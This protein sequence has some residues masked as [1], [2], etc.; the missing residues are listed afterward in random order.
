MAKIT[1]VYMLV[2]GQQTG[3]TMQQFQSMRDADPAIRSR[4]FIAVDNRLYEATPEQ[5]REWKREQNRKAYQKSSFPEYGV[6]SF[7]AFVKEDGTSACE[8][9]P[10]EASDIAE[11]AA[12]ELM[13]ET[14]HRAFEKLTVEDRHL[15]QSIYFKGM[16]EREYA[17]IIG[18]SQPA[19]P[20][21]LCR[22]IRQ[23][24]KYLEN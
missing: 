4:R 5:F 24:K 21:R 15:I 18:I 17:G 22:V 23:L 1:E 20:K 2:D 12:A 3:F 19:V 13:I 14:L 11:E 6:V 9:I 8:F 10:N 16:T 7:D